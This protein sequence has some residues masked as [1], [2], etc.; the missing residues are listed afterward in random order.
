MMQ[1]LAKLFGPDERVGVS[2]FDRKWCFSP[3]KNAVADAAAKH[4]AGGPPESGATAESDF[5]GAGRRRLALAGM[6]V[7][8]ADETLV[9]GIPMTPGPRV[10][11]RPSFAMTLGEVRAKVAGGSIRGQGTLVLEGSEIRLENVDIADG[12]AL[13]VKAVNGAEVTVRNLRVE[14]AGF[15]LLPLSEAELANDDTPE[16]LRIRGYRI[17]NRGAL[18]HEFTEPGN[19]V[20]DGEA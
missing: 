10:V 9:L 2:I 3:I 16:Y 1:D 15:E 6:R 17:E 14:N 18:V 5:Y 19:Y 4:A 11:L 13:V 20:V 8:E 12:A 7:D